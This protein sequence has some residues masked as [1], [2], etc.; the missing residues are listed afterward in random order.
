MLKVYGWESQILQ[1]KIQ[2]WI[3]RELSN[4]WRRFIPTLSNDSVRST[5]KL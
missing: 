4:V 2:E 1:L 5:Q 3:W